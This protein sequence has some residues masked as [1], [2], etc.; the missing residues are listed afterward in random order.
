[1]TEQE[2]AGQSQG[3]LR[4]A[5]ERRV[6]EASGRNR[7]LAATALMR[8]G[9]DCPPEL[10]EVGTEVILHSQYSWAEIARR[11]GVTRSQAVYRFRRLLTSAGV[12]DNGLP[13]EGG[14]GGG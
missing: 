1:M 8:L 10:E 14:R 7:K 13:Q 4:A 5:N 12:R 6:L 9:A 3:G 11:L 2:P